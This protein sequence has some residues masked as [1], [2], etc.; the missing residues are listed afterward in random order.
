LGATDVAADADVTMP[1]AR[2]TPRL[3]IAIIRRAM[4]A[5]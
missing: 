1:A 4:M 3:R 5:S 2:S